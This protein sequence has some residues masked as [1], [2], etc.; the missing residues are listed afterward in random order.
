ME[1]SKPGPSDAEAA[2]L[3]TAGVQ[4]EVEVVET[5][6]P[7]SGDVPTIIGTSQGR[8]ESRGRFESGAFSGQLGAEIAAS[9]LLESPP[10]DPLERAGSDTC[11]S[12]ELSRNDT[13]D[14]TRPTGTIRK[15]SG[16]PMVSG[17]HLLDLS[18][19]PPRNRPRSQSKPLEIQLNHKNGKTKRQTSGI[20]ISLSKK[21]SKSTVGKKRASNVIQACSLEEAKRLFLEQEAR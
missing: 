13:F 5:D 6:D 2:W 9:G 16:D 3:K 8:F 21:K 20:N 4:L 19:Q 15:P 12:P 14:E 11:A 10:M 1:E 7:P 17:V 18:P